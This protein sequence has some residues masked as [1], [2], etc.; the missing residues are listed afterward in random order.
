MGL[1]LSC[2]SAVP[3][4]IVLSAVAFQPVVSPPSQLQP[5]I[6]GTSHSQGASL[7][8]SVTDSVLRVVAAP[9][10][11]CVILHINFPMVKRLVLSV[12]QAGSD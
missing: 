11:I 6:P 12:L 10:S 7:T 9:C 3:I 2:L 8:Q 4:S 5:L 1:A